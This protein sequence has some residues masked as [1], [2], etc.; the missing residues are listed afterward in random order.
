MA[1][2]GRSPE[3][4]GGVITPAEPHVPGAGSARLAEVLGWERVPELDGEEQRRADEKLAAAQDE[5]TRLYGLAQDA[6]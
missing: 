6:A 4:I 2:D 1:S 5:A 3:A